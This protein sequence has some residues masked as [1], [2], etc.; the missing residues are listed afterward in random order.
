MYAR[1]MAGALFFAAMAVAAT[2][3]ETAAASDDPGAGL[4]DLP[5]AEVGLASKAAVV[6]EVPFNKVVRFKCNDN[7]TSCF[8]RLPAVPAKERW[9]IQFVSCRATTRSDEALQYFYL[10]VTDAEITKQRGLHYLAPT[11]ESGRET[12][13]GAAYY[14][15]S[16]P[17]VLSVAATNILHLTVVSTDHVSAECAVSGVRQKLR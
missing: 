8:G 2:V 10:L 9:A 1:S 11:Y 5:V 6:A 15:V 7:G 16:Q 4:L 12:G 3:S 13:V 17:M 14:A